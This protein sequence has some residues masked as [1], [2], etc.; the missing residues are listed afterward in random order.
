[1][2]LKNLNI[3][4]D[5]NNK[6]EQ[7]LRATLTVSFILNEVACFFLLDLYWICLSRNGSTNINKDK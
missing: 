6:T 7:V 3:D 1:M 4:V 2:I 5:T